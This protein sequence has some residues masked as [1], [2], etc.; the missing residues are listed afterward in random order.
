MF[1]YH[2]SP[3]RKTLCQRASIKKKNEILIG[4]LEILGVRSLK[5]FFCLRIFIFLFLRIAKKICTFVQK[6]IDL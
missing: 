6:K 1:L 5:S 3:R 4:I 2:G